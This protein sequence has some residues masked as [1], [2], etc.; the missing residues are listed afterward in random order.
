MWLSEVQG[1]TA[2]PLWVGLRWTQA[3]LPPHL[4]S[5]GPAHRAAPWAPNFQ[6]QLFFKNW[7]FFFL[8]GANN[9]RFGLCYTSKW[10][11]FSC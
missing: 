1:T 7:A 10:L 11:L 2:T 4:H 8:K 6:K 9:H 5:Q 3:L